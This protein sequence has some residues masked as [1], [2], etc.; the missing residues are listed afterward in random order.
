MGYY[1]GIRVAL[2]EE[3]A[4]H[5]GNGWASRR[6][7][8]KKEKLFSFR[9]MAGAEKPVVPVERKSTGFYRPGVTPREEMPSGGVFGGGMGHS[10][11]RGAAGSGLKW[12][13][14][15]GGI[16]LL[17]GAV[18]WS[19][20]RTT[21]LLQDMVGLKLSKVSVEGAHYLEEG[22]I[23]KAAGLPMGES[24][25]KLDLERTVEGV[26]SLHWAERVFIERR[27]PSSIMISVRERTPVALV[28]HGGLYGLDREGR[29]LPPSTALL[30]EDLPLI[31]GVAFTPDAVGTTLLAESLKPALDFL[32]FLGQED[33]T[34]LQSVS[35]VSLT[36]PG[37]LRVTFIDGIEASFEP[38]VSVTELK[39]MALIQS[40]LSQKGK[41]AGTLDF[42]YKD[43]VLVRTRN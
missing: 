37:S 21:T 26:R 7:E 23:V 17:L 36:E 11:V 41:R 25:F 22:E 29:V 39:R 24:M 15:L 9:M 14:R 10:I 5:T 3:K 35:E 28:D 20:E 32:G 31:S 33:G 18:V 2:R 16:V 42:R 13:L 40:D 8:G 27:L 1:R 43:M 38:P 6:Q 34:L 30:G 12:V 19:R 4:R